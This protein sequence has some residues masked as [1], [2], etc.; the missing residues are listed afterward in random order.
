MELLDTR[1]AA[2]RLGVKKHTLE[3]WR[4]SGRGPRFVKLGGLVRYPVEEITR[5]LEQALRSSTSER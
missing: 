1:E 4:V 3:N 5:F 2:K